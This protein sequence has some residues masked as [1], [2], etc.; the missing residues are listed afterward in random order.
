MPS[1]GEEHSLVL[2]CPRNG[3]SKTSAKTKLYWKAVPYRVSLNLLHQVPQPTGASRHT[4]THS[5]CRREKNK[6]LA[7]ERRNS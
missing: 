7:K 1:R 4:V 3:M 2:V 5:S 6:D